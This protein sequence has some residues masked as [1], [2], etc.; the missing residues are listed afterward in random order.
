[1]IINLAMVSKSKNESIPK[2]AFVEGLI[3][4]R[5]N[6]KRLWEKGWHL[7]GQG[8]HLNAFLLGLAAW[9]EAGKGFS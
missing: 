2:T 9:E 6:S 5:E 4:C 8:E 3:L 1:M 7:L